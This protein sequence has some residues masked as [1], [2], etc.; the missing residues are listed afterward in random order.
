MKDLRPKV[1]I[2]GSFSNPNA[3]I[4]EKNRLARQGFNVIM[5]TPE[6]FEKCKGWLTEHH[7]HNARTPSSDIVVMKH[8]HMH[9]YF[10]WI[11]QASFVHVYNEKDGKEYYGYNTVIEI[12]YCI[13][14]GIPMTSKLPPTVDE[15]KHILTIQ[16]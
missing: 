6:W 5:P 11:D 15:F 9:E 12:G 7:S 10:R 3:L 2:I 4:E 14:K 8:L 16:I 13:A 1:V